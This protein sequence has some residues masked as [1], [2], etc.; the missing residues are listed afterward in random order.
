M[1]W[2]RRRRASSGWAL[3]ALG[4]GLLVLGFAAW[5]YLPLYDNLQAARDELAA[6][7]AAVPPD[8]LTSSR[9]Q[10]QQVRGHLTAAESRFR[11]ASDVLDSDP[12]VWLAERLPGLGDQVAAVRHLSRIGLDTSGAGVNLVAVADQFL[13]MRAESG[14]GSFTERLVLLL[15]RVAPDM[16]QATQALERVQRERAALAP[17]RLAGP[18]RGG[19]EQLDKGLARL[20]PYLQAYNDNAPL[21]LTA[22]GVPHPQRYLILNQDHAELFPTGGF[23]GSYGLITFD[24]G[25]IT[26]LKFEN[27]YT[28]YFRWQARQ[29]G[30]YIEPPAL[31]KKYLLKGIS[32][33]LGEANWSPDFR[34]A[35]VDAEQLLAIEDGQRVDGV[36]GINTLA[37]QSLV[38]L[39][40]PLTL[41]DPSLTVTEQNAVET[42][43]LQ[44]RAVPGQTTDPK[45]FIGVLAR[46]LLDRLTNLE[47]SRLPELVD[48]AKKAAAE[49][50]L[51][52]AFHDP[53]LSDAVMRAGWDGRLYSGPGD[54][55]AVIETSVRSTKLGLILQR[56]LDVTVTVQADGRANH[57][58]TV[59]TTNPLE[60][61]AAERDPARVQELMERGLYGSYTRVL[62]PAGSQLRAITQDT[63]GELIAPEEAGEE[64]GRAVF[65][66]YYTVPP[67]ETNLVTYS[68]LSP[69]QSPEGE[70]RL[71][72]QKQP[73]TEAVPLRV[74]IVLPPDT[75]SAT[76][77]TPGAQVNGSVLEYEGDLSLDREIVVTYQRAR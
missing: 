1:R 3:V 53:Q 12:L 57:N 54:Y 42:I 49:R 41:D 64:D 14:A 26:E 4:I 71:Y 20:R 39:V 75:L 35:A 23:I 67:N 45:A 70:Y 13:A 68:Y 17:D 11:Q 58:V 27:V 31:L 5:R 38:G 15:Q 18:L 59:R 50:E 48:W 37:I 65:G 72:I 60:Q 36:I 8:P 29:P 10:L 16:R 40:G 55:L 47:P 33:A 63:T 76:T 19:V 30:A 34:Q 52:F 22:L 24:Q 56:S 46:A 6:A 21:V 69:R 28:L 43:L 51:L 62:A 32:W 66:A 7:Q 9:A 77:S 74:Q 73:G 61:W 44:T 2:T 25:R